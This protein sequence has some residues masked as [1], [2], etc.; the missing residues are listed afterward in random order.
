MSMSFDTS[1]Q[2]IN[3]EEIP[4]TDSEAANKDQEFSF[5]TF[6]EIFRPYDRAHLRD[7]ALRDDKTFTD[8]VN[9]GFIYSPNGDRIESKQQLL[10][11]WGDWW[12]E[13]TATAPPLYF[14]D[15]KDPEGQ[16]FKL[17]TN[18]TLLDM[19]NDIEVKNQL[20]GNS[21]LSLIQPAAAP[22]HIRP[23][24]VLEKI[25]RFFSFGLWKPT[26][27]RQ[28]ERREAIHTVEDLKQAEAQGLHVD[29]EA[30]QEYKKLWYLTP[31][32]KAAYIENKIL[33]EDAAARTEEPKPPAADRASN[34]LTPEEQLRIEASKALEHIREYKDRFPGHAA[35]YAV[36][37]AYLENCRNSPRPGQRTAVNKLY[38]SSIIDN[39]AEVLSEEENIGKVTGEQ[40]E[41]LLNVKNANVYQVAYSLSHKYIG[42]ETVRAGFLASCADD[43]AAKKI[44]MDHHGLKP[45]QPSEQPVTGKGAVHIS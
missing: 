18:G 30:K 13:H 12:K 37:E 44:I 6:T 22:E 10:D 14:M 35:G 42:R 24:S 8:A 34:R 43:P 25:G 17:K 28:Q 11:I 33:P 27:F 5:Q 32:E 36:I 41:T 3:T 15:P 1:N 4:G 26:R 21:G 2:N 40:L 45:E 16:L 9:A 31:A 38:T 20:R 7:L 29:A 23:M 19:G 39:L